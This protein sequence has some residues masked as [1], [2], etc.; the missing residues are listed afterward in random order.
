MTELIALY[1]QAEQLHIEVDCYALSKREALSMIDKDG[2]CY[3]AL[4]PDKLADSCDERT[5]LTHEIGH[6]VTGSFY[7][8]WAACDIRQKHE[9][10]ADKW[11]IERLIT[12]EELDEA[13]AQG[14]TD[15][16]QLAEH[17]GVTEA[18]MRKAV[19]WYTHGNLA[20]ELY[21]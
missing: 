19:C 3:I 11:A 5:K 8:Q 16:W 15:L 17:F 4:D 18:F 14:N 21:F 6:C 2:A 9:N 13:V 12:E 20:A 10:C 1:Q 7:N